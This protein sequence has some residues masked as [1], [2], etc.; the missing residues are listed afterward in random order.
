MSEKDRIFYEY[1]GNTISKENK[2][3]RSWCYFKY[4]TNEI[5]F[6]LN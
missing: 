5:N 3:G 4:N 6:Y 1:P 2:K